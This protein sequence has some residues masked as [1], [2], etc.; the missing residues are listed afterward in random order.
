MAKNPVLPA[1][2]KVRISIQIHPIKICSK[3]R[4]IGYFRAGWLT[5]LKKIGEM[6]I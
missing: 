2:S 5:S 4:M 6:K 1:S 3:M